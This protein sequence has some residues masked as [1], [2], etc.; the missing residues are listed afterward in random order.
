MAHGWKT[1]EQ[2]TREYYGE[3]WEENILALAEEK[4]LMEKAGITPAAWDGREL[5]EE[6]DDKKKE[7]K[8]GK[9]E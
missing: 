9:E 2:V 3:N 6:D 5:D 8:D 1:N 7:E 4:K